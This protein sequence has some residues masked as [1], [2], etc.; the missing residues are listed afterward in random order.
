MSKK[1]FGSLA[2]LA[3]MAIASA[4]AFAV[5]T[6]SG[7]VAV[8]ATTVATVSIAFSS[9]TSGIALTGSG[10]SAATIAFGNVQDYGGSVPTH[11]TKTSGVSSWTLATPFDVMVHVANQTS[12]DY[13]LSAQLLSSEG[14]YTWDVGGNTIINASSTQITALGAYDTAVPYTF[15]LT[16]P[17]STAAGSISN[18]I[19]FLATAN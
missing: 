12:T 6:G 15:T 19:S 8:T 3:L 2:L 9:D 5:T 10:T 7:S 18:T 4:P 1:V 11:V 14:T 16:I 13:T 17:A